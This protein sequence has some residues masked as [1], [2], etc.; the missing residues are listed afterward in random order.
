MPMVVRGCMS[1]ARQRSFRRLAH[2]DR[3]DAFIGIA[4]RE[5]RRHTYLCIEALT[6]V[7]ARAE[8]RL[9]VYT[10]SLLTGIRVTT[11]KHMHVSFTFSATG[12][13]VILKKKREP[14]LS[15]ARPS[16]EAVQPA[17]SRSVY[18]LARPFPKHLLE[19]SL[20]I[21]AMHLLRDPA[22]AY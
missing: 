14:A 6:R 19:L 16:S 3:G 18:C 12:R 4:Q 8:R 22:A 9:M 21:L 2:S 13:F 20:A 17:R 1:L 7:Y 15:S 10:S 11:R 5:R